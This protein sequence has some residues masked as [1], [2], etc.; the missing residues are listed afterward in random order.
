MG[1]SGPEVAERLWSPLNINVKSDFVDAKVRRKG[2]TL[3]LLQAAVAYARTA[4][5]LGLA[6]DEALRIVEAAVRAG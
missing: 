3:G 2:V 5:R 1:I 4:A 6:E